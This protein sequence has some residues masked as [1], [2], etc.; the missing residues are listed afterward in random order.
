LNIKKIIK[1]IK[2][3]IYNKP[4]GYISPVDNCNVGKKDE[5]NNRKNVKVD[6]E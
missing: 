2:T 1:K 5:F 4:V 3:V 6:D